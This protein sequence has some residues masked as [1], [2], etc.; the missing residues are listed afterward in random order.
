[1]STAENIAID[2]RVD[3]LESSISSQAG[4][5]VRTTLV[6]YGRGEEPDYLT[7]GEVLAAAE[8]EPRVVEVRRIPDLE[9]LIDPILRTRVLRHTLSP[10]GQAEFDR[11]KLLPGVRLID[12]EIKCHEGQ[13]KAILSK[14][15]TV[16]AFGGNRGGKTMILIARLF[17]RWMLRGGP[18]VNGK[19][20]ILWWVGPDSTKIIE[21]GVWT[22]AGQ[23]GRGVWPAEVFAAWAP[24]PLTKKNPT[25]EMVDGSIIAFKHANFTGA[26]AGKNLK[27]ANVVDAVIDELGAI[28]A[29]ANYHQVQVRVSQTGGSVSCS[30]T[31]VTNHWSH[32]E[33]TMRA[34]DSGPEVVD[35]STFTLFDNPW[36]TYARIWQLFLNDRTVTA[37]QLEEVIL[38][39]E[40]KI[41]ACLSLVTNPRSLREHLGIE[42][43]T[44]NRMWEEWSDD[45][46][47]SDNLTTHPDGIHVRS[48]EGKPVK[49]VNITREVLARKWPNATQAFNSW[50]GL[51]FNIRGHAVTFELFGQ[52]GSVQEA[53]VNEQ[54]WTVLVNQEVQVNGTTLKLAEALVS[55]AGRIPVW[56]DPHGTPHQARGSSESNTDAQILRQAGLTAGPCNGTDLK[57]RPLQLS[58]IESRN[59]LHWL[60]NRGRFLVHSRCTGTLEAMRKDQR[61]QDG[62]IQKTSSPNSESDFL[63]GYSDSVRYGCWPVFRGV[64]ARITAAE[65]QSSK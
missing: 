42:T 19:A 38:P 28:R 36:M 39:A 59:V 35:V 40:D 43:S 54:S 23:D 13:V 3:L 1:V 11:L 16:A 20:R 2:R 51:D 49:L 15:P 6:V 5:W 30:T 22:I 45:F 33:I 29:F 34:K 27:S 44:S 47:Y 57:G 26:S 60:M 7:V 8:R 24:C 58:Q 65:S 32:E 25:L 53:I 62:R 61:Q 50:A 21:E 52:G 63:S 12:H 17:R 10:E 18:P 4:L 46:I 41:A 9:L 14:A 56:Y 64:F 48:P 37:K 31:R 55:Q